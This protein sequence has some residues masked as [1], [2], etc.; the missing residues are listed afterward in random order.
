[1]GRQRTRRRIGEAAQLLQQQR[2]LED[3]LDRLDQVRLERR[4]VLLARI[5][6][7]E[8]LLQGLRAFV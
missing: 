6:R 7:L 5:A 4:R 2:V 8:K 3:A 1:M